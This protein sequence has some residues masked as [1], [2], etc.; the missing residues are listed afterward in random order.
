ML[1][2]VDRPRTTTRTASSGSP[3]TWPAPTTTRWPST[4]SSRG[5][6]RSTRPYG[7]CPECTGLGIRKEVDP[8]LVVPDPDLTLAEGAIAPWST[9]P[10]RRLLRPDDVAVSAR[11]WASTS[12]RRGASFRPRRARRCWRAATSRCTSATATA[13]AA[14]RS[15]YADFE[16]VIPFLQRRHD[17][18]RVRADAGALRGLHARGAVP[19]VRRRP[20]QA[21]DPGGHAGG[22]G[23]RSKS[24]AE[25]CE[26]PI[27][28]CAEFLN[29]LDAGPARAGDRRAGAQ[30]GPVARLGFLL[31]VG[32]DYLSPVARGGHPVRRRGAAHPAGHPDRLGPGRRALRPRRAVDRPAPARQPPADRDPHPAARSGQ[33]P[34]RGRARRGHHPPTP[35]GW[36]TSARRAGE[37]GG[38]VVH[39][40]HRPRTCCRTT[41][42]HHRRLPV[43]PA[44]DRRARRSAARSTGASS[45]PSSA[46]REHN[47]RDIDVAFPARR[48]SSRS[49]GCRARAS[50]P[51]S[52]TS[53]TSVL[54]NKLNGAAAGPGPAHAGSPASTSSTRWCTSTSR[55]SGALRG[56]TRP[57]TPGCSTTSASCSPRPPRRRSAATSPAGSRSTSKAAAARPAPATAPSRSR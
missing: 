39:S 15:Y 13:T 14:T 28:D 20:A 27:A 53:S 21:G 54:A 31:D 35:T 55:R 50:R 10:Q 57:P 43:G 44:S 40:G 5:R 2:F 30:G 46:P 48:A 32:L 47:L 25:V 3:R 41:D 16:G 49:P 17:R 45:S 42:S 1:D 11:R 26:L 38:Q 22:R 24:I 19:G 29:E 37:H 34:D 23:A 6:S 33:H 9:G 52:T 4:S 12:T 56:R 36:S 7:A 8:D 51:W 18:D